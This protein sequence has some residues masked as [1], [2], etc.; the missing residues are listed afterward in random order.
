MRIEKERSDK[1]V[2]GFESSCCPHD[3]RNAA[4]NF[5]LQSRF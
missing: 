1:V 4:T 3:D 2:D 5:E